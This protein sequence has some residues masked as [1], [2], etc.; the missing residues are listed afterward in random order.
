MNEASREEFFSSNKIDDD[1]RVELESLLGYANT[2]SQF[3]EQPAVAHSPDLIANGTDAAKGR[4][5]GA[6]TVDREIGLGGMGAVYLA[7]RSDGKF[8]QQ[9]ALKL[10]RREFSVRSVRE[11]FQREID[12]QSSLVHP[13]IARILDTGTTEDGIPYIAMEYVEGEPIDQY[14]FKR[15]LS[16][17][18]RLKLFNK[19]CEGVAFAHS[20]LV[21]HRDIKPS[22]ILVTADG[23]PKLIDFGISKLI[24]S[25]ENA[26]TLFGAMTP[27]YASPEQIDGRPVTTATDVYSLG[28]VLYKLVAGRLPFDLTSGA[29]ADMRSLITQSEASNPSLRAS[30]RG[31]PPIDISGDIDNIV[32]KA[33]RK[34]A[35]DRY[36]TVE[37]FA[38]DIW[39]SMDG[40]PVRARP[41]TWS[42]RAAKFVKRNR[43]A[44]AA[45]FAIAISLIAGIAMTAWQSRVAMAES[46]N[47]RSE[48]AKSEKMA[49]YM[50]KIIGYANPGWYAEGAKQKGEARVIDALNELA[51]KIDADFPN[52]IDIAA[53]LH[54]RFSEVYGWVSRAKPAGPEKENYREKAKLHA[55]RAL[56][57]RTRY[58]GDWHVLVAKDL[59]STYGLLSSDPYEQCRLFDRAINMMRSTDPTNRNFP[60]MLTDYAAFIS[61]IDDH[62]RTVPCRQTVTPQTNESRHEIAIRYYREAMPYLKMHFPN[63]EGPVI[64]AECRLGVSLALQGKAGEAATYRATC[65]AYAD[66]A[67]D[68]A[69]KKLRLIDV[70][71]IDKALA[72]TPR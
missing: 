60:F 57:L 8:N 36:Q 63:D 6:Y 35:V 51:D 67:I 9:V 46:A 20:N 62:P 42:Y 15:N 66:K 53:E 32:L 54:Y 22:N 19:A 27:E 72:E 39:R 14:C 17:G 45:G 70:E 30:E 49:K 69:E 23:N 56:E 38:D 37:Q 4:S 64:Y 58:H 11:A 5:I 40:L 25:E 29:T 21:I 47:A 7:S 1:I 28:V 55:L 12:I 2:D 24:D 61:Y 33:L 31:V 52:D 59:Y 41:S 10:L 44:V 34:D 13:N 65:A 16:L 43:I 48:Q 71:R 18:D 26:T 68:D 3:L 50:A